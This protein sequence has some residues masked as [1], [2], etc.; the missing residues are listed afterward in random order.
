[1]IIISPKLVLQSLVTPS[2]FSMYEQ[3]DEGH[4]NSQTARHHHDD[5]AVCHKI[6][7]LVIST[8]LILF[9]SINPSW[10]LTMN[11]DSY[12]NNSPSFLSMSFHD[13]I[14]QS[15]FRIDPPSLAKHRT[16]FRNEN[17]VPATCNPVTPPTSRSTYN[18]Q[19]SP[20]ENKACIEAPSFSSGLSMRDD[21]LTIQLTTAKGAWIFILPRPS[22]AWQALFR[23]DDSHFTQYQ[24]TINFSY[25]IVQCELLIYVVLIHP[26][27]MTTSKSLAI[28]NPATFQVWN[29]FM[30]S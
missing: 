3:E 25:C 26:F 23:V 6:K 24:G 14:E 19:L 8:R 11:F 28:I 21:Y 9:P 16:S 2:R 20:W 17:P 27:P 1:M 30:C 4:S 12:P 10:F 13:S 7:L 5:I 15:Q 22:Q 18:I 29:R